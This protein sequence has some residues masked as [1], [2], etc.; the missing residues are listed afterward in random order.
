MSR[1]P[2]WVEAVAVGVALVGPTG[3]V[4]AGQ[5]EQLKAPDGRVAYRI[6]CSSSHAKRLDCDAKARKRCGGDYDVLSST[7]FLGADGVAW[8]LDI[9]CK[10]SAA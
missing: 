2:G 10:A 1:K 8:S 5:F 6:G 7:E 3:C 9:A 4:S